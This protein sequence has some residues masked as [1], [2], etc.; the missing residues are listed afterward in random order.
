MQVLAHRFSRGRPQLIEQGY[1][2]LAEYPFSSELKRKAV[3]L[4]RPILGDTKQGTPASCVA[5]LKGAVE[6]VLDACVSI[7]IPGESKGDRA[8]EAADHEEIIGHVDRMA[9]SGL[10][11]LALAGREWEADTESVER[12]EVEKDMVFLGLVG[13]YDPPRTL[14]SIAVAFED[15]SNTQIYA[16]Y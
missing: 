1:E 14:L 6:R 13:I 10:R 5:L 7:Q 15:T 9:E 16:P 2:Q 3:I 4:R 12:G 11:V 8:F